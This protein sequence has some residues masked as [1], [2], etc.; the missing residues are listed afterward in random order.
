MG[1]W[2]CSSVFLNEYAPP[3]N[4]TYVYTL[5][6]HDALPISRSCRSTPP[7]AAAKSPRCRSSTSPTRR[8]SPCTWPPP[9][10]SMRWAPTRSEEHTSELK[11]LIRTSYAV[12]CLKKKRIIPPTPHL[13]SSISTLQPSYPLHTPHSHI[14]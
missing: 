5:A 13:T 2:C 14:T 11:L 9:T 3:N 6:L 12:C 1:S 4:Y 8:R 7:K 10:P